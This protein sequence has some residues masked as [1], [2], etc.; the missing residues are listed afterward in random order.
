MFPRRTD[1]LRRIRRVRSK[2]EAQIA[3]A[4]YVELAR[5]WRVVYPRLRRLDA[6]RPKVI[7][8]WEEGAHPLRS[9]YA[10]AKQYQIGMDLWA[11]FRQRLQNRLLRM[12]WDGAITLAALEAD[13]LTGILGEPIQLVPEEIAD[14]LE[15]GIAALIKNVE[16]AIRRESGHLIVQWYNMPGRTLGDLVGDL[17]GMPGSPFGPARAK[18]IAVTEVTRLNAA[19]QDH[20]AGE[21]G[22][23]EWDWL[24]MRDQ[25]VCVRPLIGPDGGKYL[26]CRQLHGKVFRIGQRMPPEGSHI[27]CRCVPRLRIASRLTKWVEDQHPR[28]KGGEFAPKGEGETHGEMV[29]PAHGGRKPVPGMRKPMRRPEEFIKPKGQAPIPPP[30]PKKGPKPEPPPIAPPAPKPAALKPVPA[31]APAPAPAKPKAEPKPKEQA[32][33]QPKVFVPAKTAAEVSKRFEKLSRTMRLTNNPDDIADKLAE[34][35]ARNAGVKRG[36][37]H[38]D[39]YVAAQKALLQPV[40]EEFFVKIGN[41][42]LQAVEEG[43]AGSCAVAVHAERRNGQ[44]HN[45]HGCFHPKENLIQIVATEQEQGRVVK[46]LASGPPHISHAYADPYMAHYIHEYGHYYSMTVKPEILERAKSVY[47]DPENGSNIRHYISQYAFT[48]PAE[49]AAECWAAYHH[50]DFEKMDERGKKI[51]RHVLNGDPL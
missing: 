27:G 3:S 47:A 40:P 38:W 18:N 51:V 2:I 49:L 46:P 14:S 32:K 36:E 37:T 48:N 42:I 10:L 9:V 41:S 17:T 50:D 34:R 28:D 21:L 8:K 33:E 12:L 13:H 5:M 7:A 6:V 19:V 43:R 45:Y 16:E 44:D 35:E 30:A 31:P 39:H 25:S 11:L 4:V 23:Q 24:T 20:I 15:G 29:V 1:H 26:G 22:I